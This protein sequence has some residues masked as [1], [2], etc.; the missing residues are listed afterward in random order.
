[1][2]RQGPPPGERPIFAEEWLVAVLDS[3]EEAVLALDGDGRLIACNPAAEELLGVAVNDVRGWHF[4]DLAPELRQGDGAP[5]GDAHPVVATVHDRRARQVVPATLAVN[6][7]R[8]YV[9]L[10]TS[11]L[12]AVAAGEAGGIVVSLFDITD[13][14]RAETALRDQT[15]ELAAAYEQLQQLDELKGDL[16]SKTSH[17]L[18][19]PLAT[20]L[21]YVELLTG[22]WDVLPEAERRG[23]VED[24]GEAADELSRRLGDLIVAARLTGGM[25][26]AE[27]QVVSAARLV[28]EAI[29]DV[30]DAASVRVAAPSEVSVELDPEHGRRMIGHLVENAV[31]YGEPPV[32]VEVCQP[33]PGVTEIAVTDHGEGVDPAFV[34]RLFE[35]FTQGSMGTRRAVSGTGLG[36]AI[37]RGLAELNRGDVRYEPN[38]PNGSRF[39]LRLRAP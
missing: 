14:V 35:V 11:V 4:L 26:R 39:V 9:R 25:V 10:N 20:V 21:G 6:G 30:P 17:E 24:L 37:V 15:A 13:L 2:T 7:E 22:H 8:R 38:Q 29:A 12:P 36:L 3:L 16:I 34:P 32:G 5:F 33:R 28:S 27:P 31:K 1:M 19:T 18:R 23:H